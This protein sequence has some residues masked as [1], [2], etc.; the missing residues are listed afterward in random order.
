MIDASTIV[1]P[2]NVADLIATRLF[3]QGVIDP[4]ADPNLRVALY[5]RPLRPTDAY[6]AV[7]VFPTLWLPNDDSYEILGGPM[8]GPS[9]PSLQRYW[10]SV[11]C[12]VRDTDETSGLAVHSVLSARVRTVLYRDVPLRVGLGALVVSLNGV[13]ERYKRHGVRQQRYLASEVQGSFLYLS[14]VEYWIETEII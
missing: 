5:K 7:G 8:P 4:E 14:T 1:F 10:I 13:V 2:N 11:Q 3:V 12:F 9:E 6:Q